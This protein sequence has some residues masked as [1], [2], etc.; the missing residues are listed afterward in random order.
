MMCGRVVVVSDLLE[1]IV[2][3]RRFPK[4]PLNQRIERWPRIDKGG[5]IW[6]GEG[7]TLLSLRIKIRWNILKYINIHRNTV[8]FSTLI[9]Y[10]YRWFKCLK[11]VSRGYQ[12]LGRFVG[13]GERPGK[14][15]QP[16]SCWVRISVSL[17]FGEHTYNIYIYTIL[18]IY[19][20]IYI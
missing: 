18:Y 11:V 17:F 12:E 5:L 19:S 16:G 1:K 3:T 7:A 8:L 2:T 6:S 10:H 4:G 14:W 13:T 9:I 20:I 15:L